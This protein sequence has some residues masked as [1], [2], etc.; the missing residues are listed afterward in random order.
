MK[1]M[2]KIGLILVLCLG[3]FTLLAQTTVKGKVTDGKEP[4]IGANVSVK[5]TTEGTVT[6][7][8]G[9][10]ELTTSQATPFK[11]VVTMVGMATSEMEIS[12][13]QNDL[14][15]KLSE[16]T[17]LLN[18]V[19]V[20]ASRVEEKI[21]ESPVTIE[22]MDQKMVKAAA[23][24]DYYDD[25]AKLKG[26]QTINGSMTL[27]SVNTRGF[28]GISNTR[29]V[30][31][32]D[33]MDNAAPLLNFPTGNV[34]GIGELDINNVELVPGAASALYGPNAFNGILLMNSKNP[35]E[36]PGFSMQVKGGFA[37]AGNGYGVKPM[38]TAA[39]RVAHAFKCKKTGEDFAAFK[40]NFSIFQ[41]TDWYAND[42][43]TTRNNAAALG[44][45]GFDGMNLYGDES[46]IFEVSPTALPGL[47][48]AMV[49]NGILAVT[50]SVRA[51][52]TAG[53]EAKIRALVT[54]GVIAQ[55]KAGIKAQLILGGASEQD[56]E[57]QASQQAPIVVANSPTYQ[58]I[59]NTQT[60]AILATK[61]RD[62]DSAT[63]VNAALMLLRM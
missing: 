25:L 11:L 35:F 6:D 26:V 4:V 3:S 50:P 22:K 58:G 53:Y 15:I 43:T 34:V 39:L 48:G 31:L 55:V 16:E 47:F 2:N 44:T 18:D 57:A 12:G 60:A 14:A 30:Q 17:S 5:G 56:A 51:Q 19:V 41:G 20:S 23:S 63:A 32:M 52:V 59:I 36:Q 8:D 13:S 24:A 61:S 37:Q 42:Y 29:F 38:G 10:F 9:N 27:T 45:P 28:G 62:I 1:Q 21:L 33:G 54:A 49:G 7:I 40:A 46:N